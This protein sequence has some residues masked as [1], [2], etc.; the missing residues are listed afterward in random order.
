MILDTTVTPSRHP[1]RLLVVDD[2]LASRKSLAM[3]LEKRGYQVDAAEGAAAAL[4]KVLRKHYDLVLL[5][6]RMPE[7]SGLDLLKLLRATH[8]ETD[9]PV[10]MVTGADDHGTIVAALHEGANDYVIK[11]VSGPEIVARVQAQLSRAEQ[12]RNAEAQPD[13]GAGAEVAWEW[14][15]SSG[16]VRYSR[17]WK[18]FVGCGQGCGGGLNEWFDRVHP[19][20][21]LRVRREFQV[22]LNSTATEFRSEHRLHRGGGRYRWVACRATAARDGQG[23]P[24]RVAGSFTDIDARKTTDPLTGLGNRQRLQDAMAALAKPAAE[25]TKRHPWM[26]LLLDLNGFRAFNEHHGEATGD[27][28]LVRAARR[29]EEAVASSS[30]A[31]GATLARCGSD[32]FAVVAHCDADARDTTALAEALLDALAK[33]LPEDELQV[34]LH[35]NIGIALS[36][37]SGVTIE[38]MLTS[39]TQALKIAQA[40]GP[41]RWHL[42]APDLRERARLHQIIARD[43][44]YAIERNELVAFYQPQIC[45]ATRR[46]VGFE[47]LLRWRHPVLGLLMP[48]DFIPIAEDTSLIATLGEWMLGEACRQ[49]RAWQDRFPFAPPV[50]VAVNVSPRQL[51]G[52]GLL[53]RLQRILDESGVRPEMLDLELTESCMLGDPD[54][55]HRILTAL[56]QIGVRLTLDDFGTGYANLAHLKVVR[57]DTLK[58]DRSFVARMDSESESLA[59]VKTILALALDLR[60]GVIAEG[61]ECESQLATLSSMGCQVGQGYYF[62]KPVDAAAAG[63]MLRRFSQQREP[64]YVA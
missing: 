57:F 7:M 52:P 63:E 36:D 64:S 58:I 39:A 62:A 19:L 12:A 14:D 2:D 47:A 56:H 4:E 61:I 10:I 13:G 45:L 30:F 11:P 25:D 44:P 26:V 21:L 32:E 1:S 37:G 43:L 9:L 17:A 8:S 35:T 29:I 20:D 33:P 41:N 24:V 23:K 3:R 28:L 15:P 60:M 27:Q 42:S 18:D 53:D 50:T 40:E 38:Q 16:A 5:D 48:G 59:I 6:Q 49:L 31:K 51:H 55:V 34:P 46:L 54:S 22:Y